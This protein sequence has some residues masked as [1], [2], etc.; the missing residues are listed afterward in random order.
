M[1]VFSSSIISGME[2]FREVR[3]HHRSS[4]LPTLSGR[5]FVSVIGRL[6]GLTLQKAEEKLFNRFVGTRE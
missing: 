2:P 4:D 1:K 6:I 3:T 5:H